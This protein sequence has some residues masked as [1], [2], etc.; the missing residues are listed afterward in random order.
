MAVTARHAEGTDLRKD[1]P[2]SSA[3]ACPTSMIAGAAY[4]SATPKEHIMKKLILAALAAT[5]FLSGCV[6]APDDQHRYRGDHRGEYRGDDRGAFRG[7]VDH[8][9]GPVR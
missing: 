6:I 1:S 4:C 9:H 8:D 2:D 7:D 3:R 5:A